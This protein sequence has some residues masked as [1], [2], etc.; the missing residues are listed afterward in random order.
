MQNRKGF[1][2]LFLVVGAVLLSGLVT[3][4]LFLSEMNER[5][6]NES[7]LS[8]IVVTFSEFLI[9]I[10]SFFFFLLTLKMFRGKRA[11]GQAVVWYRIPSLTFCLAG[12]CFGAIAIWEYFSGSF[13]FF[14]MGVSFRSSS[15]CLCIASLQ[16][17]QLSFCV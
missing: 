7:N 11:T 13:L 3:S 15:R 16:L 17:W 5:K 6:L 9:G 4:V 12:L 14:F 1:I 8:F 10:L 2:P